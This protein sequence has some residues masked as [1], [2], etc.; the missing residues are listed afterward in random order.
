MPNEFM[1]RAAINGG[2]LQIGIAA[3]PKNVAIQRIR[4]I[5]DAADLGGRLG[6]PWQI[7]IHFT[8]TV[9]KK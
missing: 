5:Q 3:V 6:G 2:L 1:R 8:V 9:P 7:S 4:S